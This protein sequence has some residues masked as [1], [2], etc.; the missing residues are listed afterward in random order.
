MKYTYPILLSLVC[1]LASCIGD[2]VIFDTV[3]EEIR[4]LNPIDSLGVGDT[5]Q[6]EAS[7]INQVGQMEDQTITW[8]SSEPSLVSIDA[9]GLAIGLA[10]GNALIEA[11]VNR[12][13]K[14]PVIQTLSLVVGDNTS[15][16]PNQR[17]GTI[18]TTSSYTLEGDFVLKQG[19]SGLVLEIAENYQASE[20]LPG[21]YIYLTNNPATSNGALEIG[22][23]EVFR[24]AH[25]YALPAEVELNTYN[26]VLY[27][28]K[29]FNVK[30]G[31]GKM[32]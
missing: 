11:S 14:A 6:F 27:F 8:S 19:D 7:F 20:A 2:D 12:P 26:Y 31:D 25:S 24:G 18:Q 30:V 10:R 28:C 17:E 13:D 16:N 4:I 22:E 15:E 9:T 5:Y 32:E 29:P 21:L 23:V 3:A 1:L